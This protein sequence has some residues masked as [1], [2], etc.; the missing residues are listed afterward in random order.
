MTAE[1]NYVDTDVFGLARPSPSFG[2]LSACGDERMYDLFGRSYQLSLLLHIS[3][4]QGR[5]TMSRL[6]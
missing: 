6:S 4:S 3:V 2:R 5:S 1:S